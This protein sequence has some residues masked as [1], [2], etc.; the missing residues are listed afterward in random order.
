MIGRGK[1]GVAN[2]D[3]WLKKVKAD[4]GTSFGYVVPSTSIIPADILKKLRDEGISI[5]EIATK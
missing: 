1:K 2:I 4:G 5:I 3:E